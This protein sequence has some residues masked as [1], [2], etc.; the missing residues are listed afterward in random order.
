[1]KFEEKL[2][3]AVFIVVATMWMLRGLAGLIPSLAPA[4]PSSRLIAFVT[5]VAKLDYA[6]P[7]LLGVCA[8]LLTGVLDWDDIVSERGAWDVFLW[9]GGLLRMA[10]AL[11]ETGITKRFAETAAGFTTGW[12]WSLALA[13][14]LLIYFYAHYAFASITAHVTAMYTPFL[15]VILAAGAPPYLA[16]LSMAYFSNLGASL[17]HYG[18]TPAPIYFGAGYVTQ[19][20][21]WLLGLLVSVPNILIWTIFGFGWWK[22]LRWW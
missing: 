15:V 5:D 1:M 13:A 12:K 19:R 3:L 22:I 21:W 11:G 20:T 2:L 6:I 16:V 8:L 18:T 9:Y 14:L 7:P 10:E 4:I 17:T